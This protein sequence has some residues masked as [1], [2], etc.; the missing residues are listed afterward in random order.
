MMQFRL[1]II[2]REI[3]ALVMLISAL[4]VRATRRATLL[5]KLSGKLSKRENEK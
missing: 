5:R 2:R 4:E 1:A 3:M